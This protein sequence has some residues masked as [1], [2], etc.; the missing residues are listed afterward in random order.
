MVL[1]SVL[2]QK[3]K[4]LR[5]LMYFLP[6]KKVKERRVTERQIDGAGS[7]WPNPFRKRVRDGIFPTTS[8]EASRGRK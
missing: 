6:L 7:K 3:S 4:L 8:G 5:A 2:G 1:N